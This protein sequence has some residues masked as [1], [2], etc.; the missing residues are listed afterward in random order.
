LSQPRQPTCRSGDGEKLTDGVDEGELENDGDGG[1]EGV[2][3][4]LTLEE[5]DDEGD[6]LDVTDALAVAVTLG[7][8]LSEALAL[9]LALAD[10]DP[11]PVPE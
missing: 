2:I 7:L 1:G 6:A 11:D 3:E 9:A 5:C 10:T 8:P 4:A